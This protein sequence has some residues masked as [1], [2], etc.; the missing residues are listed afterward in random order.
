MI[1][2]EGELAIAGRLKT[3]HVF[4]C[5]MD[6]CMVGSAYGLLMN[7]LINISR[8]SESVHQKLIEMSVSVLQTSKLC[9][10]Q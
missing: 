4:S 5:P 8:Y 2:R 9:C 10:Y 7:K 6:R 1:E 3:L